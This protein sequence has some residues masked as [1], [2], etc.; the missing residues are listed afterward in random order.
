MYKPDNR[1]TCCPQYTI[2][3]D[4]TKFK[5]SRSQKRAMRQMNEFLATGKRPVCGIKEEDAPVEMVWLLNSITQTR[6]VLLFAQ[7]NRFLF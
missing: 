7:K 6:D 1:V 4:V 5:M 3:L 2:R